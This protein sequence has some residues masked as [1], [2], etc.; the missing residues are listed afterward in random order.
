MKSIPLIMK[1]MCNPF[2]LWELGYCCNS[3][4]L[5]LL[6]KTKLHF[7]FHLLM[8]NRLMVGVMMKILVKVIQNL[9]Q[10][11]SKF[12]AILF[13]LFNHLLL[14]L[15][16]SIYYTQCAIKTIKG[17]SRIK[18][19]F[20][21]RYLSL[22]GLFWAKKP[23]ILGTLTIMTVGGYGFF[24]KRKSF[25]KKV[26]LISYENWAIDYCRITIWYQT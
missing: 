3:G 13:Y 25:F 26:V 24:E 11:M 10:I 2:R 17:L 16:L 6:S 20:Y 21:V 22:P 9:K 1:R 4:M 18:G 12:T 23:L 8:M 7:L 5:G 14:I 19:W 15:V